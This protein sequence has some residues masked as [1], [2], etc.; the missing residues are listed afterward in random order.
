MKQA[1]LADRVADDL[2]RRIRAG[3]LARGERLPTEAELCVEFGVSRT[4]V[5]EATRFL[6]ARGVVAVRAGAGATVA[7]VDSDAA[8]ESLA[9]FLEGCPVTE[10]AAMH[11]VREV[12][13]VRSAR[14]AAERASADD[15]T[16]LAERHEA[17]VALVDTGDLDGLARADLA[18]H[19]ALAD[20]A[21]NDILSTLLEALGPTLMRPREVNL[22]DAEARAEAIDSHG[23]ILDAVRAGAADRAELAMLA[24]MRRVIGIYADLA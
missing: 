3:E 23:A 15:L 17:M 12:L 19:T 22:V 10:Y 11:E 9:L 2:L 21:H 18:F 24:H 7:T 14:W 6:V 1:R 5:R 13:E 8:T 16:L 20:A 4:V